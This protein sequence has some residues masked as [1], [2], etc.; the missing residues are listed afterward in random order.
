MNFFERVTKVKAKDVFLANGTLI[1]VAE[2]GKAG[3][4]VGKAGV[5]LKELAKRLNKSVKIVSYS[6]DPLGLV[7]SFLFPVKPEQADVDSSGVIN[8]RFKTTR[9]RRDLLSDKQSKLRM[10]EELVRR[11]FPQIK[12]IRVL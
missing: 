11:Y 7:S 5:N 8:L 1:F 10:M 4:A 9:N 2:Q 6:E 3:L 12:G